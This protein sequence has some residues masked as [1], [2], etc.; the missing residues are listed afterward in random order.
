[1]Q[2]CPSPGCNWTNHIFLAL[3]CQFLFQSEKVGESSGID[4]SSHP[5]KKG[6][7]RGCVA[8]R[9]AGSGGSCGVAG[10]VGALPVYA[11]AE[12]IAAS[13]GVQMNRCQL[14]SSSA[15]KNIN[16]FG[17]NTSLPTSGPIGRF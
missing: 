15:S 2:I 6:A 16:E 7:N 12:T 9:S 17:T 3:H 11:A 5:S 10:P 4:S 1:M 13:F 8:R 14:P